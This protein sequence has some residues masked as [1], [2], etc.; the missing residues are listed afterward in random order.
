MMSRAHWGTEG[1]FIQIRR[2]RLKNPTLGL[3]G[4][5]AKLNASPALTNEEIDAV[6]K[7]FFVTSASI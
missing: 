7:Q 3:Y 6:R 1:F 4:V 2:I 5:I